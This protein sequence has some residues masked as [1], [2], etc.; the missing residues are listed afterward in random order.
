ME[1][2]T[3]ASQS[4]PHYG[5]S[6]LHCPE[7]HQPARLSCHDFPFQSSVRHYHSWKRG[8][9]TRT[10][11]HNM[12]SL[13]KVEFRRRINSKL[14]L[15]KSSFRGILSLATYV[16]CNFLAV[17]L[18][19]R[20]RSWR[21]SSRFLRRL[22]RVRL[23]LMCS[24]SFLSVCSSSSSLAPEPQKN[25]WLRPPPV[26]QPT[27]GMGGTDCPVSSLPHLNHCCSPDSTTTK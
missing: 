16:F 19:W 6:A 20:F 9:K 10:R 21:I 1:K 25:E 24:F 12:R 27:V 8:K 5:H 26:T 7:K 4:G 23:P 3:D 13:T 14:S 18:E 17:F 15:D 11:T 2:R 22:C